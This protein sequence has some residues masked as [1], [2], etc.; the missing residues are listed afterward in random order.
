MAW[1]SCPDVGEPRRCVM[2]SDQALRRIDGIHSERLKDGP[3]RERA[4]PMGTHDEGGP[5]RRVPPSPSGSSEPQEKLV[6]ESAHAHS[7]YLSKQGDKSC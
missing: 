2:L 7:Y 6:A 5:V 4:A 3:R 1:E